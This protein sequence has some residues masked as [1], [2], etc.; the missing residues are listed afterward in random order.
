[1][2]IR[3]DLYLV[4]LKEVAILEQLRLEEALLR[5]RDENFCIINQGSS[6]AI[7]MGISG[8]PKALL[9][10][11]GVA[12]EKIPVIKRFSGGGTVIVDENTLFVTFIISKGALKIPAFPEP[13][14]KW[15]EEF[16]KKSWQI[17]GFHLRENDYCIGDRKCGGNAQ[18][19]RK[20]RWL[21]HTSFLWDYSKD[22]MNHL[23]L[24]QKRPSYRRDRSHETFLTRL[25]N[26]A[27]TSNLLV[28]KLKNSLQDWDVKPLDM[29][30]ILSSKWAAEPYRQSTRLL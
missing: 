9:H 19:I 7:V 28:E 13:I 29:E 5:T 18:Y 8:D 11:E 16:Y 14:L 2:V 25:K 30:E 21:H 12:A 22:N 23:L 27:E 3:P 20:N 6:R 15:S 1:M 17:P 10:L 4:H 26:Y 24:P